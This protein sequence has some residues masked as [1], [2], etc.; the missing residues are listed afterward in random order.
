MGRYRVDFVLPEKKVVLE[1]DGTLYHSKGNG[2]RDGLIILALGPG[3]E[4]VRITDALINR[5]I[6]RLVP[7]IDEI[8]EYRKIIRKKSRENIF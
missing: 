5:D 8:I 4:M 7:A 1:V 3:W 2:D 6:V